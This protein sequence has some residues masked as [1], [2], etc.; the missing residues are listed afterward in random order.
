LKAGAGLESEKP[1]IGKSYHCIMLSYID[2]FTHADR[3]QNKQPHTVAAIPT[4]QWRNL[5]AAGYATSK[6]RA[7]IDHL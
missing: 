2:N 1:V 4:V 3:P 7:A 6:E 5:H